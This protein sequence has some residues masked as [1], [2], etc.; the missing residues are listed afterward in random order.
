LIKEETQESIE[1]IHPDLQLK[2][3]ESIECKPVVAPPK[4]RGRKNE[5]Q[6][7]LLET[8]YDEYLEGMD[9]KQWANAIKKTGMNKKQINK[10]LWDIKNRTF[11]ADIE[12]K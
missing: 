9:E 4:A 12:A 2:K 10:Y 8:F 5:K 3:E 1:E 7:K 6:M 11:K